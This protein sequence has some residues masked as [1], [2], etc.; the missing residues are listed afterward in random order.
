MTEAEWLASTDLHEML[1]FLDGK[2]S[3]RKVK[4]FA[5]ACCR[6]I[7]SYF[8]SR[9]SRRA[10]EA[11]EKAIDDPAESGDLA[12]SL[13]HSRAYC[14]SD[15]ARSTE[16]GCSAAFAAASLAELYPEEKQIWIATRT[17]ECA[18]NAHYWVAHEAA[19]LR[20]CD[21]TLAQIMGE[22]SELCEATVQA[23]LLRE[24]V[25]NPFRRIAIEPRWLSSDVIA[26]AR[27]IYDDRAFDRLPILADA[28]L[29]ARC[30][31]ADILDHCRS[32]GPH[33]RGCWVVDLLTGRS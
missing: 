1:A 26:L 6:R 29:D 20:G 25:P 17:S 10:V 19:T 31:N 4:L 3:D 22:T 8:Q 2:A 15:D 28:L 7:W 9:L 12:D 32:P 5:V 18:R 21:Q 27:G 14:D 16:T 24:I 13:R 11:V 30:D 23:A 33:V